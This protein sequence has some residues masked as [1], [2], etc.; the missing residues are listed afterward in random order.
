MTPIR[1]LKYIAL[2]AARSLYRPVTRRGWC[3]GTAL[4]LLFAVP[5]LG[6]NIPV[7]GFHGDEAGWIPAA[8][9]TAEAVVSLDAHDDVWEGHDLLLYGGINPPLG[10]MMIGL[11]LRVWESA[12]HAEVDP[13]PVYN[14]NQS[15][16]LNIIEGRV[17]PLPQ[18]YAARAICA[19]YALGACLAVFAMAS[20]AL[21][22]EIGVLAGWLTAGN[23][24]FIQSST[25]AMTDAP[26]ILVMMLGG[27]AAMA[28]LASQSWRRVLLWATACGVTAGFAYSIKVTGVVLLA[29]VFLCVLFARRRGAGRPW[30]LYA[31]AFACYG[32]AAFLAPVL[33]NP[34]FWPDPDAFD[35][36]ALAAEWRAMRGGAG[37][38]AAPSPGAVW[39]DLTDPKYTR[40]VV[41]SHYPQAANLLRPLE[42]PILLFRWNRL[43]RAVGEERAE[44]YRVSPPTIGEIVRFTTGRFRTIPGTPLWL[45][46][47]GSL[48]AFAVVKGRR[49]IR[50]SVFPLLWYAVQ[51][52]FLF[53]F[54]TTAYNRYFLPAIIATQVLAAAGLFP[55]S[56]AAW[57]AARPGMDFLRDALLAE[58]DAGDGAAWA[59]K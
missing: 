50:V 42:M 48:I 51:M 7:T 9:E 34:L 58:E 12:R 52:A 31:L 6:F 24:V 15:V 10:K 23:W 22:L 55:L 2:D 21:R 59:P 16:E 26:Y 54:L 56:R 1:T 25:S 33:I 57:H 39:E 18:L 44:K 14:W 27:L 3:A 41:D 49:R 11:P 32:V 38:G 35:G 43:L 37:A 45:L 36:T 20:V 46:A 30:R 17:P 5:V 4:V 28:L 13:N 8:L 29:V 53:L 47:G 40:D 19:F